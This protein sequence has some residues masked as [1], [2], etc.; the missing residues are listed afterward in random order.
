MGGIKHL[1]GGLEKTIEEAK[2]FAASV[3]M[4]HTAK[5][6]MD[7]KALAEV[8]ADQAT[9]ATALSQITALLETMNASKPN[10]CNQGGGGEVMEA[11]TAVAA[12]V[13]LLITAHCVTHGDGTRRRIVSSWQGTNPGYQ[14]GA[15]TWL[16]PMGTRNTI[17][18]VQILVRYIW[19]GLNQ[20]IVRI[21]TLCQL[22]ITTGTRLITKLKC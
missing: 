18:R 6:N 5:E 14:S 17:R 4:L 20:I 2:Y 12:A 15:K 19:R 3:S 8:K 21:N 13:P 22:W 1:R 11:A 16:P 9:T 10:H 7:E